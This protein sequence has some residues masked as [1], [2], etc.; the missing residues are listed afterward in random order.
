MKEFIKFTLA[1]VTGLIVT[2]GICLFLCILVVSAIVAFASSPQ[3]T[4]VRENSVMVLDLTGSVTEQ[5]TEDSPVD[6][7]MGN[8]S[9]TMGLKEILTAIED[10]K[11]TPQIK[12]IYLRAGD[13]QAGPATLKAIRDALLDFKEEKF[14]VAYGDNYTQGCY[15]LCSVA[16]MVTLNPIGSVDWVGLSSQTMY[17]KDLLEKVGVDMQIFKVGTYKA[18]VEPFTSNSMGDANREQITAYLQSI[19]DKVVNGVA[20]SRKIC[21]DSLNGFADRFISAGE[22]AE[23]VR[24]GMV[25]TLIYQN[26]VKEVLKAYAGVE[27]DDD[28][29]LLSLSDM[30]NIPLGE[31]T[32]VEDGI[33][34]YYAEGEIDGTTMEEEGIDSQRMSRTLRELAEEDDIKAVV[35]RVN[36]PGGSAFGSEQIWNEVKKL[37]AKKPVIV[38]MGDYAASGGYYISC[39][40]TKI[41]AEPTTLTGSIGIFGMV[42]SFEKV[43]TEKLGL[44]IEEVKTNKFAGTNGIVRSFNDEERGYV[45]QSVNRGYELF[46][47]R[48][49]EGRGLSTDSVK[50]LAE[51]RVWIGEAAQKS[52]LVDQLGGIDTAIAMAAIEANIDDY[53]L[54][55]YPRKESMLTK[56]LNRKRDDYIRETLRSKMPELYPCVEF[57]QNIDKKDK[58]QARLPFGLN[59]N[60]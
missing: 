6:M 50:S 19:W 29:N 14:I 8:Q 2:G 39:A 10:A 51:G 12:G 33:A 23:L 44:R 27:E 18:A 31:A 5:A 36:S 40:A 9:N 26:D 37:K 57:I 16:D 59:L 20:A 41:V 58:L 49:A 32:S 35:L 52:G 46:V 38:S 7:L 42:P 48:C 28:L 56:L 60:L 30:M 53:Y 4:E 54:V 17:F 47:S 55:D 43:L 1:T 11:Y 3:E 25:D 45:Q 13:L 15:Y 21:P 22:T 34:V 24:V